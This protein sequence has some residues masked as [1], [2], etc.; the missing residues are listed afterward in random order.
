MADRIFGL[1]F[2]TTNSLPALVVNNVTPELYGE[3]NR[4]YPSIVWYRGGETVVGR[5]ARDHF[6]S[7][8]GGAPGFV[9][10][11]KMRLRREGPVYV[12]GRELDAEDIVSDVLRHVREETERVHRPYRI[13]NAVI[14]VP[15]DFEGPQRRALR[16]AASKAGIRVA[17]FVH[18][19]AAAL[20]GWLC[21]RPDYLHELARLENRTVLVF[22]WGG[23]TLDI[24]ICRIIG[25]VVMQITSRGNNDVGGDRFDERLC[26]FVRDRHAEK[27]G[28]VDIGTREQPGAAAKLLN[29]CET[30]KIRLSDNESALALSQGYVEGTGDECD[31]AVNVSRSDLNE[32]SRDLIAKGLDEIERALDDARLDRRDIELCLATGGMVNMP[33]IRGGLTERFGARVPTLEN[34][35]RIIAEGAAWIAHNGLNIRLSKPLEVLVAGDA[36]RGT[37]LP[38]VDAN[39][40]LPVENE[41]V[42]AGNRRFYC[43][44]PRDGQAV[45]EFGKPIKAGIN[46]PGDERKSME[47]L[48]LPVD[49]TTRPLLER[50][51]C[52]VQIDHDYIATV[53]AFSSGA[54]KTVSTEIHD[55]DFGLALPQKT[56]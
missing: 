49:P 24:T 40:R 10:S 34:E 6:D 29:Q 53:T 4:P 14:A 17:C 47:T 30:V 39:L 33:A 5:D 15:V 25:G 9:R 18:E 41:S 19:P 2:G 51:Q 50:L 55:L 12:E 45:F 20:Y 38:L 31:L 56:G 32:M 46:Q 44:D 23:G 16:R 54:E 52:D 13:E 11:P 35:D 48:I 1:D 42:A 8:A 26:N 37:W 27:Y 22:D 28:I 7:L 43:T 3:D 36:G 21:G